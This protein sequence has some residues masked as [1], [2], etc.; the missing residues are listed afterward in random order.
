MLNII[1][2]ILKNVDLGG[3]LG[4]K[5]SAIVWCVTGYSYFRGKKNQPQPQPKS[6]PTQHDINKSIACIM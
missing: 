1:Q 5:L 4:I 2:S 3:G 6:K